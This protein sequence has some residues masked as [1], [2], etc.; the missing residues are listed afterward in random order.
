MSL[1]RGTFACVP[2]GKFIPR[3]SDVKCSGSLVLFSC[4]KSDETR[5]LFYNFLADTVP[6]LVY[7]LSGLFHR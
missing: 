5:F 1:C 2:R 4:K 3:I 7:C 6:N